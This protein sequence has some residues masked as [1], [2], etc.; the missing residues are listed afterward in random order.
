MGAGV[1]ICSGTEWRTVKQCLNVPAA[2]VG[3][4]PYGEHFRIRLGDRPCVFF[5]C[6]RTRVRAAGAC[7]YAIDRWRVDPVIVLGT[8]GGV[9]ERLQVGDVVLATRT[10]QYDCQDQRPG[11]GAETTADLSWIDL[12]ATIGKLHRGPV[13]SADHDLT[14]ND[15][16]PLRAVGILV[17]DWESAAIAAVC[18]FNGVR[19]AIFRGVSDVPMLAGEADHQRQLADYAQ[20]TPSIMERLLPM[21]PLIVAA[22]T[23]GRR[24]TTESDTEPPAGAAV[25]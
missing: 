3:T 11:M 12:P 22:S 14:F 21:L 23:S 25:C 9:A 10:L 5:H 6:R 16:A 13:A 19:W 7:Q 18:Q 15:V 24:A 8:C 4:F 2:K 1:Q 17:A 20:N